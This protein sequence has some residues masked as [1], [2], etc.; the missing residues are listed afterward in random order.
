MQF[1]QKEHRI[2]FC[3][4]GVHYY[5]LA[6]LFL[7]KSRS[8]EW[9]AP[10]DFRCQHVFNLLKQIRGHVASDSAQKGIEIGSVTAIAD[11]YGIGD[12]TLNMKRLFTP[13]EEQ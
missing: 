2:G 12:L 7:R 3:R 11:D 9:A 4:D 5:F 1:T 6:Q 13:L 10:A 8:E